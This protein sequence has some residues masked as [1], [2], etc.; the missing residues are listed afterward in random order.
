M[1]KIKFGTDGWRGV[2]GEDFILE[3]VRVVAQAIA[4][5]INSTRPAKKEVA[6]GYDARTLSPES[7]R[8]VTEVLAGNGIR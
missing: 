5:Y 2:V 6:V 8:A 7:A 3:T 4:D 1:T